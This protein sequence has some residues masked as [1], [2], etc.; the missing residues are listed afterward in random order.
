MRIIGIAA[1][2][3]LAASVTAAAGPA[4]VASPPVSRNVVNVVDD[5]RP[6]DVEVISA[7]AAFWKR[8][9][10]RELANLQKTLRE[11]ILRQQAP[12]NFC[13]AA[14][15][16]ADPCRPFAL[17]NSSVGCVCELQQRQ[18]QQGVDEAKSALATFVPLRP[19][20]DAFFTVEKT[21]NYEGNII[22]YIGL[23]WKGEEKVYPIK[24]FLRWE[25]SLLTVVRTESLN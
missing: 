16:A 18:N 25:G 21:D 7:V 19:M 15:I 3:L 9:D 1:M 12:D 20:S 22:S 23:R 10:D 13:T 24:V 2:L 8:T 5:A 11:R 4:L 17:A 14:R 6:S